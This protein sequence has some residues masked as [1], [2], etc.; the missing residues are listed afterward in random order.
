[1][2]KKIKKGESEKSKLDPLI[3][4]ELTFSNSD[5][6]LDITNEGIR[7]KDASERYEKF[8]SNVQ[9]IFDGSLSYAFSESDIE[10]NCSFHDSKKNL[11]DSFEVKDLKISFYQ[12][13]NSGSDSENSHT[14]E[15]E[16]DFWINI[17]RDPKVIEVQTK[18][19]KVSDLIDPKS[20]T[21]KVLNKLFNEVFSEKGSANYGD[22]KLT[23]SKHGGG[24]INVDFKSSGLLNFSDVAELI[25]KWELVK[26]PEGKSLLEY[27]PQTAAR[28]SAT[29]YKRVK[30]NNNLLDDIKKYLEVNLPDERLVFKSYWDHPQVA[31]FP[32]VAGHEYD[33][34]KRYPDL[35]DIKKEKPDE[36]YKEESGKDFCNT[37]LNEAKVFAH[38]Q[39]VNIEHI[40]CESSF[41]RIEFREFTAQKSIQDI[42]DGFGIISEV[43]LKI[44]NVRNAFD[45]MDLKIKEGLG[46]EIAAKDFE[47]EESESI[48]FTEKYPSKRDKSWQDLAR[49][50]EEKNSAINL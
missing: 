31:L 3:G 4:L 46:M 18:P 47:K 14:K 49:T 44:E 40:F 6:E 39:A 22:K 17:T 43:L 5:T 16:P 25:E 27:E 15:R 30:G 24:H 9:K 29:R 50:K 7:G 42:L 26:C 20:L 10:L 2:N 33:E 21:S 35:K 11:G 1:M 8:L 13:G 38:N 32:H 12:D 23:A 45:K 41:K 19:F 36:H 48:K 28:L 37:I 34:H